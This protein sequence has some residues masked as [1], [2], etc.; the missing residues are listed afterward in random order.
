MPTKEITPNERRIV[1]FVDRIV[2]FIGAH[3]VALVA[4]G[5]FLFSAPPVLAPILMYYG[6][7]G[8]ANAIYSV[9][10]L[11]CHE[12]AYRTY[13]LGGQ[14]PAYT[15]DQLR[16]ALN[17]QNDDLYYWWNFQG[18]AV[19][20]YKMAL[21]ERC[22]AIYGSMFFGSILFGLVRTRLKP[23][24]L[25]LYLVLLAPMAV[26]GVTQLFGLRE[27]D[28]VLRTITG[29][30]F[31]LGSLWLTYPYLEESMREMKEQAADQYRRGKA[32]EAI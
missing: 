29:V 4:F 21:C 22:M 24:D 31:G 20:G 15:I 28:Y 9:Y 23:L 26:D 16:T 3:W 7:T 12:L 17:V 14:Q 13:F 27:S 2:V 18:N 19:L 1:L 11:T 30:L 8:P 6:I 32:H 5:L 25:R 10:H